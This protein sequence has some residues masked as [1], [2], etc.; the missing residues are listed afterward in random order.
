MLLSRTLRPRSRKRKR[1]LWSGSSS[2]TRS[3]PRRKKWSRRVVAEFEDVV[4]LV[5]EDCKSQKELAEK[6]LQKALEAKQQA[7]SDLEALEKSF[8][9]F[10][11]RFTKQKEAIEGFQKNEET[12]KK[13]VV[14]YLERIKKEEQRYQAL[15]A[16]AEEK[17][18]QANEEIA[19]VRSKAKSEVA[20][21]EASLRIEQMRV[22]SLE[23]TLEQKEKENK[24]LTKICDELIS[25]MEK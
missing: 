2:T 17:L 3:L 19:Q 1:R 14:D 6:E 18:D 12:L 20:A 22:Q 16:H 24:E 7:V 21:L 10:F 15:K 9:E 5:V 11:N 13:C 23:S 8:S 25:K 4:G